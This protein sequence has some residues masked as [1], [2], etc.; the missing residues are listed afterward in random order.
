[1]E[2]VP[3]W[4]KVAAA[5]VFIILAVCFIYLLIKYIRVFWNKLK[6][7]EAW[8]VALFL[9]FSALFVS[10][11]CDK[12]DLN[13]THFGRVIEESAECWA[14][15]FLFLCVIQLIPILVIQHKNP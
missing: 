9:W 4:Q 14:A 3:L 5:T 10:Q 12:S 8:A 15:I 13:H 1:M 7:L 2:T 6:E 11:L